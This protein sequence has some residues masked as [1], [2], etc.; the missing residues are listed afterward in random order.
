MKQQLTIFFILIM[1]AGNIFPFGNGIDSSGKT[2][3]QYIESFPYEEISD[4]ERSSLLHLREEEKLARDVYSY[5]YDIWGM[6]IFNNISSSEQKHMDAIEAILHK[7]NIPDPVISND[8]GV[9][10]DEGLKELY[11]K[12]ITLGERS[13]SDALFV[14]ATIEDLDIFDLQNALLKID[15]IDIIFVFSNLKKGSENHIRAFTSQLKRFNITYQAQ[16]ISQEELDI[17]LSSNGNGKGRGR[18]N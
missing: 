8:R 5:L 2:I 3:D 17:I 16:Y 9:F 4:I 10:A 14:G 13:L 1:V 11:T 15:N 6:R 7:Y 12:L 18:N